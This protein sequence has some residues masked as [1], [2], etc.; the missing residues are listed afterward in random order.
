MR[1]DVAVAKELGAAGVVLGVLTPDAVIDRDQTAALIALARP[2]A[3]TFHK[4][5]D[6]VREPLEALEAL[7]TLG[8]ERILTSGG[9]ATALEGVENLA[10]LVDHAAG[11]IAV[12]A[13]GRLGAANLETVIRRGRVSDV[14][15]G[16]AV[17]RT[18][19]SAMNMPSLDQSMN[20]WNCSRPELVAEIVRLVQSIRG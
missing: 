13:G 12:M 3:V 2:L 9:R 7:I 5:F 4:A 20:S 17:S 1:H 11:R 14:H 18:I 19:D 6:Q 16:S 10:N 15:L 8:A